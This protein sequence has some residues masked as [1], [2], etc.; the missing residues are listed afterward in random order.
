MSSVYDHHQTHDSQG[1][2]S[3]QIGKVQEWRSVC[4]SLR[5]CKDCG[6]SI[7]HAGVELGFKHECGKSECPSCRKVVVLRE[8]K[9][10][11][12]KVKKPKKKNEDEESFFVTSDDESDDE[13]GDKQEK[14]TYF[15]YFDI[16]ARQE[17][18]D[19]VPNLLVA[20]QGDDPHFH[21]FFGEDC[22]EQFIDW[23]DEHMK[24]I[25]PDDT[26][27]IVAHNLKGYDGYM[28]LE[29]YYNRLLF[30]TLTM[31]G[32]KIMAM[33]DRRVKF[34]DSL[35]FFPVALASFPKTFGI[36]ERKKGFFPQFFNTKE[37]E[38]Y[39]GPIPDQLL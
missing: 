1:R 15:V 24:L 35:N 10:F 11:L 32:A 36:T 8:H 7:R 3:D 29:E 30:P 22:V 33:E 14:R 38:A 13:E 25:E 21:N 34:I 37:N 2:T 20:Q 18:G 19:H 26:M 12:Q 6:V 27:V 16:E 5:R 39:V 4:D 17:T 9:C 31:S 28:I 23:V